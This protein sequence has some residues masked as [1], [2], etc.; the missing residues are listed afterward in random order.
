M[1]LGDVA[2]LRGKLQGFFQEARE[3]IAASIVVSPVDVSEILQKLSLSRVSLEDQASKKQCE[4]QKTE[5]LEQEMAKPETRTR[6]LHVQV[7]EQKSVIFQLDLETADT[8]GQID[9]LKKEIQAKQA[10][11]QGRQLANLEATRLGLVELL[12]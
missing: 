11:R 7:Q 1:G 4:V 3:M 2:D 12:K 8:S 5:K 9:I 6:D 10:S